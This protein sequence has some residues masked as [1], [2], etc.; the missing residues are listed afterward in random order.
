[1]GYAIFANRKIMLTNRLNNLQVEL[2]SLENQ[3]QHILDYQAT[4]ADGEITSEERANDV[5]NWR[6]YDAIEEIFQT[7]EGYHN[8]VTGE[9]VQGEWTPYI[10]SAVGGYMEEFYAQNPSPTIDE[11][12]IATANAHDNIVSSL[13][14]D[15]VNEVEAKR[16]A[17]LENKIDME[18]KRVE[19]KI[20]ATQNELQAVEQAEG[21][22]IKNATP[23][24]NGVG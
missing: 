24:Y 20:S 9:D 15:Y 22:A 21:Q 19:T 2:M 14:V 11:E 3:R 4:I 12:A 1:M 13:R 23:K 6:R 16:L 18:M 5:A 7:K 17:A 8:D 10:T